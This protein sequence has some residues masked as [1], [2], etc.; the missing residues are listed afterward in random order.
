MSDNN[1]GGWVHSPQVFRK[2]FRYEEPGFYNEYQA[3]S[4]HLRV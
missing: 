1:V 2:E 3:D 4:T